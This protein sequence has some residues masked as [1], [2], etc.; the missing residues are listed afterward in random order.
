MAGSW[1]KYAPEQ[2]RERNRELWNLMETQAKTKN[3]VRKLSDSQDRNH[4]VIQF[5]GLGTVHLMLSEDDGKV[6]GGEYENEMIQRVLTIHLKNALIEIEQ[7]RKV[8]FNH[9]G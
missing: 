2:V 9:H 7:K 1:T 5:G 3:L 8:R 6:W 4:A